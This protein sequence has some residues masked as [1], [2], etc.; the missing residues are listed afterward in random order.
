MNTVAQLLAR[1]SLFLVTID[2][3]APVIN[4]L[5]SMAEKNIGALVVMEGNRYMGI[6]TERDYSRKVVLKGKNSTTT[7]VEEIM[8]TQLPRLAPSDSTE[9]CM[10]LMSDKHIR[11]MP[12]FENNELVGLISMS[13]VVKGMISTQR[14]T[15]QQ[16]QTYISS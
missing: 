5:E 15:I 3:K 2:P 8:T 13:D 4:A 12:V 6:I 14:D 10:E 16:L 9:H 7:P 1:K 11:Y